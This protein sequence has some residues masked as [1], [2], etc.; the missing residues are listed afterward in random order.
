[1]SERKDLRAAGRTAD[2]RKTRIEQGRRLKQLHVARGYKNATK[3]SDFLGISGPTYL[4]HCNG[5]RQIRDDMAKF[6][7]EKFRSSAAWIL[8]GAGSMND[9]DT[10]VSNLNDGDLVAEV[11]T[12]LSR[13]EGAASKLTPAAKAMILSGLERA[14]GL[15]SS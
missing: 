13:V 3:A 15:L 12:V 5:T 14:K 11:A 8:F 4:A 2:A 7:A 10:S 6:Y 9:A 1:M